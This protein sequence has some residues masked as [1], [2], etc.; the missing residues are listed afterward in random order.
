MFSMW[1]FAHKVVATNCRFSYPILSLKTYFDGVN[2]KP[3][4]S[5]LLSTGSRTVWNP[6]VN[7][8]RCD[9]S[10]SVKSHSIGGEWV[11]HKSFLRLWPSC[12]W[13]GVSAFSMHH[14]QMQTKYYK[15]QNSTRSCTRCKG[16]MTL[17]QQYKV[18]I[19]QRCKACYPNLLN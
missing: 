12:S 18:Q 6:N 9:C 13:S 8:R 16:M 4:Q 7:P 3:F 19:T 11:Q 14:Y 17:K 10:G 5:A 15:P 1:H 2:S